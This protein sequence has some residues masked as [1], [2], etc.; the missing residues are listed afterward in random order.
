MLEGVVANYFLVDTVD[1]IHSCL[2]SEIP[3]NTKT[4]MIVIRTNKC[5][6]YTIHL[7]GLQGHLQWVGSVLP[8]GVDQYGLPEVAP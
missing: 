7:L 1:E 8:L 3:G 6:K 2:E 5:V 4:T